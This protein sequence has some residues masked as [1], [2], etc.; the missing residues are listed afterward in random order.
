MASL[1]ADESIYILKIVVSFWGVPR[2]P[3]QIDERVFEDNVNS[4]RALDIGY[5]I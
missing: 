1:Y 2:I 5:R 4:F 3:I